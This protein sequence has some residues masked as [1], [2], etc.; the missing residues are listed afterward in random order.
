MAIK[1]G[2]T[3][4][5]DV[6]FK[7][8]TGG[9]LNDVL[10]RDV[11]KGK[12]VVV[13]AVPGAF[14]PTCSKEHL[15]GFVRQAE[16]LKKKGV[17]DVVC[18]AVNDAFVMDAWGTQQGAK[19]KVRLLADGNAEFAK[20]VG[21]EVDA[22]GFGMGLRSRRYAM[23]VND[24]KVEELLVEPGPGLSCSSAETVLSKLG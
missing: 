10:A 6:K 23:L 22:S 16:A 15:P 17:D 7:E 21:L 11:F 8:L 4:P 1:E 14:T 2:D 19:G 5:L 20:A 9:G 12:K 3:L 18:V 24:G 13:F